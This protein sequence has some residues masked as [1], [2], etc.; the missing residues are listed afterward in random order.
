MVVDVKEATMAVA[1]IT[2][3]SKGFGRA[4]AI[5]LARN[6][7]DLVIDARRSG[8]LD[9]TAAELRTFGTTVHSIAGDVADAAHRDALVGAAERLGRLDLLV[10]NASTLGP[11]PLPTLD[12]YPL[13]ELEQVYRVN[14]IAPLALVQ[15][16]LPLLRD[17]NGAVVA[18]TS[19]AAVENYEGWG[20]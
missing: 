6:G 9:A 10:N 17:S 11:S 14:V 12:Q 8:E 13:A 4:L 2:G 20:G 18:I 3:A 1:I 5:D 16:A 7:W 15:R 19:D